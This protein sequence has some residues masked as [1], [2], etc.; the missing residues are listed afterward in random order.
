MTK[1]VVI[2]LPGEDGLWLADMG[3]GTVTAV[4]EA[5][6]RALRQ[7]EDFEDTGGIYKNVNLAV[8]VSGTAS[9]AAGF[10]DG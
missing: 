1:V 10:L 2:G 6:S 3:A 7:S 4:S 9:V 5:T 8:A